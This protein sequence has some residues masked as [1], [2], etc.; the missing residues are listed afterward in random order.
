LA[1]LLHL[2]TEVAGEASF[3]SVVPIAVTNY[4]RADYAKSALYAAVGDIAAK[5]H[6]QLEQPH[7]QSLILAANSPG[8]SSALV[9]A[10]VLEAATPLGFQ[11][12]AKGLF[13]SYLTSALRPDY[14][15]P[16]GESGILLE[17]E[18]GKTTINNMDLLDFWK[19]HLCEHANYLFL[20]VPQELRQNQTLSPRREYQTVV[21][22]LASFFTPDN[23]TNVHGLFVF[24]Y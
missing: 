3:D 24:G 6:E 13:A 18:R 12:E 4:V 11:S 23:Y 16:I 17:V 21:R 7:A 14:F 20:M 15:L 9:Q 10:A 22:R 1:P 2:A 8:S 5:S 19:C